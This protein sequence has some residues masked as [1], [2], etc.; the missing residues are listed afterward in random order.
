MNDLQQVEVLK[1]KTLV[2]LYL[3][4]MSTKRSCY[5]IKA[6]QTNVVYK[7]QGSPVK[8]YEYYGDGI[9]KFNAVETFIKLKF[10]SKQELFSHRQFFIILH[11]I[12]NF[13]FE[14]YAPVKI[15]FFGR[16]FAPRSMKNILAGCKN[17]R[18]ILPVRKNRIQIFYV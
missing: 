16:T 2:I 10:L 13:F 15:W 8:I 5:N 3:S 18:K 17:T 11:R 6:L 7:F 14:F 9:Y 12:V 1:D 4:R